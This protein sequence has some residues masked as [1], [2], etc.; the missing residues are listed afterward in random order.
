MSASFV[1]RMLAWHRAHGR[2]DLPWQR[3]RTPYRVWV[4]EIMLQQTQ[5]DDRRSILR[6]LHRRVSRRRRA[7]GRRRST[8][9]CTQWS[10][11]GYYA[12]ARNLH[13]AASAIVRARTRGELAG[14]R[15]TTCA[16]CPA[17]AARPRARSSRCRAAQRHPDSRR[18]RQARARALS[19]R[20]AAGPASR[21]SRRRLLGARRGAHAGERRRALHA[22]DD[23]SR[24][25]GMHARGRRVTRVSARDRLSCA[26]ARPSERSCR[27][28]RPAGRFP[29]A[30]ARDAHR[31]QR[32]TGAV[33]L[34][35]RAAGRR[36]GADCGAFRSSQRRREHAGLAASDASAA[37]AMRRAS[38]RCVAP[39]LH[40]LSP[41]HRAVARARSSPRPARVDGEPGDSSGITENAPIA[42]G[43]ATPVRSLIAQLDETRRWREW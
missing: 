26:R 36:V 37:P 13:A 23:G 12:R 39:H 7:R 3:A 9:C 29:C 14:R 25:D 20:R 38:G 5:V 32:P 41:R 15:S 42:L 2:H 33:L 22:G 35:Q 43:L 16:R 34:E 31:R 27:A 24:R 18:Q 28:P 11:L 10:G 30:A 1:G 19:R 21:R 6:A 4:S 17:S 8:R 40:A